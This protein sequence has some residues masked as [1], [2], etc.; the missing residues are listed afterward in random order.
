MPTINSAKKDSLSS[1]RE[2]LVISFYTAG[3]PY[4]EEAEILI[5]S[6]KRWRLEYLIEARPSLGS[7]EKNCAQKP[8]FILEK[9]KEHKRAIFWTDADS[10]FIKPPDFTFFEGY[11]FSVRINSG[12]EEKHPSKVISNTIYANY[13]QETEKLIEQWMKNSLDQLYDKKRKEEFWDQTA[14]RDALSTCKEARILPMPLAYS[15][16]FDSDFFKIAPSEVIVEHY[17]ASRRFK[18]VIK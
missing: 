11:D 4:E 5:A 16:I 14:L 8:L 15:K 6:C 1:R 10:V 13:T 3:T 18:S 9:L 12:L 2:P 7:W 17:Q